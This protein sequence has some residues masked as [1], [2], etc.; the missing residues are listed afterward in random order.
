MSLPQTAVAED[1]SL[2][3]AIGA[4]LRDDVGVVAVTRGDGA[5]LG[6][7]T[8]DDILR[9]VFPRY[10]DE[11]HHT[12]FLEDPPAALPPGVSAQLAKPVARELRKAVTVDLGASLWHVAERFLHCADPALI[13]VD[14][15]RFA[16]VVEEAQFCRLL[17][18]P[19]GER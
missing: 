10:L 11:L 3:D 5:V 13:A 4:L 8:Y 9:A 2:A 1:A 16:G 18:G 7:L 19:V 17:F 12:A 15:G 14:D 6:I